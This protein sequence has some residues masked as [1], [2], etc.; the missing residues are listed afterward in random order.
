MQDITMGIPPSNFVYE[1]R[2][3]T[4]ADP[5]PGV[6]TDYRLLYWTKPSDRDKFLLYGVGTD[7]KLESE[8]TWVVDGVTLPISGAARVGSLEQPYVFPEP[9]LVTSTIILYVTNNNAGAYPRA[10]PA[11]PDAEYPYEGLIY[12]RYT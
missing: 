10:D 8:Y 11:D 3:S 1:R 12:G 5:V 7:Q 9:L 4:I 6:T 2:S